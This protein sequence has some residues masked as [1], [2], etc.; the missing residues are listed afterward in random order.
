M[1][2]PLILIADD[3]AE[4]VDSY[5]ELLVAA[6]YRVGK[7]YDGQQAI[8]QALTLRPD[9]VLMDLDMPGIDGWEATRRLRA[10]LRTHRIPIIALTGYGLRRY[11][12]RSF[13]AGCIA[14]IDK[15]CDARTL[16][17]EVE[18]ALRRRVTLGA[19][20]DILTDVGSGPALLTPPP[21]PHRHNR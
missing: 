18:R 3:N 16:M 2:G 17:A 13:E 8:D 19:V 5:T 14:F 21:R 4:I 7:A 11:R 6:G 20:V 9:V 15:P 10:D 12:D 1:S